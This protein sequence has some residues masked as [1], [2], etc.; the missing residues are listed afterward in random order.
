MIKITGKQ[1]Q[2]C[3]TCITTKPMANQ[4]N[5]TAVDWLISKLPK[6]PPDTIPDEEWFGIIGEA[7]DMYREQLTN[8]VQS[9]MD[10]TAESHNILGHDDREASEFVDIF[11]NGCKHGE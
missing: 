6:F 11:L 9:L 1:R 4:N 8:L 3:M 5:T 2:N 10:Y 7:R